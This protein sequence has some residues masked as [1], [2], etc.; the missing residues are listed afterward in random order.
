LT[1]IQ[2]GLPIERS[3]VRQFPEEGLAC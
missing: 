2:I 1:V 3:T